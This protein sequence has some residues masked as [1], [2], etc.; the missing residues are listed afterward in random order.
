MAAA[1]EGGG[2]DQ[3]T[4]A[5]PLRRLLT[6]VPRTKRAPAAIPRVKRYVLRHIDPDWRDAIWD[7]ERGVHRVW[8]DDYLNQTIW[9]R[10]RAHVGGPQEWVKGKDG[11]RPQLAKRTSARYGSILKV[12]V[13]FVEEPEEG[14][15]PRI[16]V[17]LFGHEDRDSDEGADDHAGHGDEGEGSRA[18]AAE[19]PA[20]KPASTSAAGKSVKAEA[21]KPAAAAKPKKEGG[22]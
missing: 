19:A 3:K 13:L 15:D 2:K 6:G 17:K 22:D 12:N 1:A 21:K 16:E 10:G 5:V 9:S 14:A 7:E 11:G 4:I 18:K 20:K 8:I